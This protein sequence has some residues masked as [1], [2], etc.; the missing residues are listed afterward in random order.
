MCKCTPNIRTPFCGKPG[1]E[2]PKPEG[3][4]HQMTTKH[5]YQAAL[6]CMFLLTGHSGGA[7]GTPEEFNAFCCLH[8]HTIRHALATMQRV[9]WQPIE[10]APKDGTQIFLGCAKRKR[11][12]KGFWKEIPDDLE[13]K[14]FDCMSLNR[15]R[16]LR[17]HGGY[18]SAH[19]RGHQPLSY[20]PTHWMPLP[21]APDVAGGDDV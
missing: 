20:K 10:T 19:F 5:D 8:W 11:V 16:L 9:Q 12:G 18:W 6:D 21:A 3:T 2:L 1:C 15:K 14:E 7:F 13:K 4:R 17:V